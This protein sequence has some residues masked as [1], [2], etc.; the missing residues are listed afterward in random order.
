MGGR[1]GVGGVGKGER[2]GVRDGGGGGKGKKG[3]A[4]G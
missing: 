3:R 4:K 1:K 2:G